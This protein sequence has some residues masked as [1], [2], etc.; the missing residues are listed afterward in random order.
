V[1]LVQQWLLHDKSALGKKSI[2]SLISESYSKVPFWDGAFSSETELLVRP[3]SHKQSQF[4][5]PKETHPHSV[6]VRHNQK[7]Q[8]WVEWELDL[9]TPRSLDS[10]DLG[11]EVCRDWWLCPLCWGVCPITCVLLKTQSFKPKSMAKGLPSIQ[12]CLSIECGC[13]WTGPRALNPG[14]VDCSISPGSVVSPTYCWVGSENS[15]TSIREVW[16]VGSWIV[17]WLV[18]LPSVMRSK[19]CHLFITTDTKRS[20]PEAIARWLFSG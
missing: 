16:V 12:S 19:T 8:L 3:E 20:R 6:W 10:G 17:Q 5:D 14:P 7:R 15:E 9:N 13:C 2:L 1:D 18:A 4:R 11:C